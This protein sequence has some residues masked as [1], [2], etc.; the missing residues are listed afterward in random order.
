MISTANDMV[1]QEKTG[2][3]RVLIFIQATWLQTLLLNGVKPGTNTSVIP[4]SAIERVATGVSVV[5]G[6]AYV[7]CRSGCQN[8]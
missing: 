5:V 7:S 2:Y 6:Q 3:T 8:P 1:R 4:V